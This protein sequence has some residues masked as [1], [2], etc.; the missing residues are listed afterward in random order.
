MSGNVHVDVSKT[1]TSF[2]LKKAMIN[3]EITYMNYPACN[4]A[5]ESFRLNK[6]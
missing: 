6:R 4:C 2:A 1:E 3:C 5:T